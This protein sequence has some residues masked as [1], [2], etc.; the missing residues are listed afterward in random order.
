MFRL[1]GKIPQSVALAVSG[2]IDSMVALHFLL[3]GRKDV[4]VVH[5]NHGTD[6]GNVAVDFVKD[7]CD[8]YGV[9]FWCNS[10]ETYVSNFTSNREAKWRDVRYEVFDRYTRLN[11]KPLITMHHLDDCVETWLFSTLNGKPKT[12]PYQRGNIIRPFLLVKSEQIKEY[13]K[14]HNVK[15]INDPSNNDYNFKRNYI[16]HRLVPEALV[17]NPGLHKMVAK[18]VERRYNKLYYG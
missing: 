13:A 9:P 7:Q 15:Y 8:Y 18:I 14:R 11:D 5:V 4:E 3:Q 6:H 17:I 1:L 10:E 2:G 16:R 12:I